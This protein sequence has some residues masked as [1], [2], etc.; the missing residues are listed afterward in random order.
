M[1]VF[2]GAELDEGGEGVVWDG[3]GFVGDLCWGWEEAEEVEGWVGWLC[4]VALEMNW[5]YGRY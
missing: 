5:T 4:G 2:G 1:E 3:E